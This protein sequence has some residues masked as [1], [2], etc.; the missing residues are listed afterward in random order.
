MPVPSAD[1]SIRQLIDIASITALE[2]VVTGLGR[3]PSPLWASPED[4]GPMGPELDMWIDQA[5][6]AIA[7]AVIAS[8]SVV[9]F[10]A[11]IIDGWIPENVRVR[12]VGAVRD[13]VGTFD[14]EGLQLPVILEGTVGIH[15][16]AIGAASL[17]LADRFLIGQKIYRKVE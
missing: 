6:K 1:G 9:D 16:R 3:D 15:A 4:W 7:H 17:P 2:K 8:S 10:E 12:I 5:A 11:A 14:L 13:H